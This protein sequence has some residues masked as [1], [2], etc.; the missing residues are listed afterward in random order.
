MSEYEVVKKYNPD[1]YDEF[2]ET[3]KQIDS[4]NKTYDLT[5]IAFEI[6]RDAIKGMEQGEGR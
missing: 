6:L 5:T 4:G 3:M 2:C 1:K